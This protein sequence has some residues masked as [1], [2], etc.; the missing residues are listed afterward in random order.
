MK[1]LKIIA[2]VVVVVILGL[3]VF[4]ATFDVS[5]YKGLI[6]DQAK[7]ATG[8]EVKIGDIK[9]SISLTPAIV[10]SDVSISNASWGS[11]PEML[12]VKRIEAGTQLI[13]LLQGD[14][15]ISD[16]ALKGVEALLEVNKSGKPNWVFDVPQT[17]SSGTPPLTISGLKVDGVSLTYK[18]AQAGQDAS[19]LLGP[20]VVKLR[21]DVSALELTHLEFNGVKVDFKD[22][23]QSAVL[24]VGETSLDAKGPIA[25]LGITQL[26]VGETTVAYKG[27][28]G[29]VDLNLKAFKIAGDGAV[30]VDGALS[31][32]PIKASGTIAP[33]AELI[34]MKKPIPAKLSLEALGLKID[35]DVVAD[36]SKQKPAISGV[37]TVPE[38]DLA[39]MMPPDPAAAPVKGAK[40]AKPA[41]GTKVFPADPLPW[42]LLSSADSDLKLNFG[43]LTLP[44]GLTLENVVVPVKLKG[45]KL[46]AD[47]IGA[48]IL[49]GRL[50]A[51]LG[52]VQSEK[53]MALKLNA[54]GFTAEKLASE[55]K[56]TDLVTQGPV[57]MAL[58]VKGQG[59][60]VRA[61]MAGLNG[62]VIG[63][64]GESRIRND[65]LNIIGAD[66]IMQLL[67]ALNPMG[68]KDPYTVAR[69]AVINFQVVNGVANTDKGLVLVTDKMDVV[70][71]GKVDLAQEQLDLAIKPRATTGISVGLG[72]LTQSFR[73]GGPLA[74][75][76]LKVDSKGAVK[77]LGTL[78]AA[79]ATGG[80]SLLAKGAVD[81]AEASSGDV[82]A[83]ARTW[84]LKKK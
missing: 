28:G 16:V 56:I 49:G 61:I 19:V 63:G 18:D 45:G 74:D 51:D 41:P 47:G 62:S 78:G 71:T 38:L 60:S 9:L 65:A 26:T 2:G 23:T 15:R 52:L 12:A 30:N 4:L 58:D 73:I 57:D 69:C 8:R 3:V 59:D 5:Q 7:A 42:A 81:K 50:T 67:S 82:C 43:K 22:K 32:Q 48:N 31:G 72:D 13:P 68:N 80:A 66:V 46:D 79:F 54:Q 44:N 37:I 83:D 39:K 36:V 84:H 33:I 10:L 20:T 40:S 35:A 24:N 1:A 55:L 75:P 29:P 21:G 70:S 17:S 14:V 34:A 25:Q 11:K 6:Q 27:Q 77:A 76:G 53:R 64:M